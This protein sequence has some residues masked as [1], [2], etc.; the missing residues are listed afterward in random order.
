MCRCNMRQWGYRE[1]GGGE[2]MGWEF[3][4]SSLVPLFRF[5]F[6]LSV[7]VTTS[8]QVPSPWDGFCPSSLSTIPF[9]K[10]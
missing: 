5:S 10:A 6:S 8:V 7:A 2:E 3:C 4:S 9:P 1:C